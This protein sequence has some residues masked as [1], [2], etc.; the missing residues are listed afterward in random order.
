MDCVFSHQHPACLG[1]LGAMPL[2]CGTC[3]RLSSWGQLLLHMRG[4]CVWRHLCGPKQVGLAAVGCGQ[5]TTFGGGRGAT[6]GGLALFRWQAIFV[7]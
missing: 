7:T 2:A 5:G 3:T 1:L 6:F 4:P